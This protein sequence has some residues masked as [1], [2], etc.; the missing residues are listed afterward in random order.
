MEFNFRK[1]FIKEVEEVKETPK[2]EQPKVSTPIVNNTAWSSQGAPVI[3]QSQNDYNAVFDEVIKN[4][5]VRNPGYREFSQAL[6]KM[7][8]KPY[9]DQQKYETIFMGFEVQGVTPAILEDTAMKLVHALEAQKVDFDKD[10]SAEEERE[11]KAKQ[12]LVETLQREN[13]ELTKKVQENTT[14]IQQLS[15]EAIEATQ[16][17]NVEKSAFENT[18]KTRVGII[19]DHINKIKL[20]LNATVSK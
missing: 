12:T 10:I 4:T 2:V 1:L 7:D 6:R 13:E 19:N 5:N 3:T 14:K 20:Y 8:G 9:T 16:S 15:N 18:L 17:L 11:V